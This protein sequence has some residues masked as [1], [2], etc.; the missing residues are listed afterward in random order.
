[1]IAAAGLNWVRIPFPF[2]AIEVYPGEPFLPKVSWTYFLKAIEWARKYGIRINLDLHTIPGSQNGW[3]HSG[4]NGEIDFMNGAMGYA[5]A[6]RTLDYIRIIAEFISQPEYAPVVPFFGIMN[7]PT[8]GAGAYSQTDIENFN[9]QA[10]RIIRNLGGTGAGNGP[11][12][13]ISEGFLG[14]SQWAGFLA[15]AD[16][17]AIDAHPYLIF[18]DLVDGP[19]SVFP[20]LPCQWGGD[21]GTSMSAFGMTIAGEWS[22]AINDC[23]LYLNG[24]GQGTRYEGTLDGGAAMGSCDTWNN[25]QSWNQSTKDALKSLGMSTM[26]SLQNWFFWTWT[27]GE[28]SA[29]GQ[30]EAP[31]WSYKLGLQEGWIVSDPRQAQGHCVSL[32]QTGNSFTGNLTGA[33]VGAVPGATP[34][35]LDTYAWP[36]NAIAGTPLAQLA[37]YTTAGPVPTLPVPTFSGPA[38]SETASLGDGWTDPADTTLMAIPVAGCT[39]PDGWAAL[40]AVAPACALNVATANVKRAAAPAPGPTARP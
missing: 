35:T 20:P 30:V 39:Y 29:T 23:G 14:L 6:Q 11:F 22:N 33:E 34:T 17:L 1:M 12:I 21:F 38:A 19:P 7:E 31:F 5:N 25:Y 8:P 36:P 18:G 24:V 28:S 40:N 37:Q 2:W 10:Y 32:G 26:D 13:S 9:A 16:R 3:N 27:I 15:G 4:K